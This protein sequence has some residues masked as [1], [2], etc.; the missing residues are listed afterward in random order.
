[1]ASFLNN[2]NKC[3]IVV[4]MYYYRGNLLILFRDIFK[5]FFIVHAIVIVSFVFNFVSCVTK[6]MRVKECIIFRLGFLCDL[7]VMGEL[8]FPKALGLRVLV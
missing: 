1:M 8:F 6:R 2:I 4:F 3:R 5:T 7:R